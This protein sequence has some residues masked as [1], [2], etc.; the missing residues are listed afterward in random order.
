MQLIH[1]PPSQDDVV[2]FLQGALT[3]RL[4][5]AKTPS[6]PEIAKDDR[7]ASCDSNTEGKCTTK[8]KDEL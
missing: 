4:R 8:P 7:G 2:E 3:G 5:L 1:F 6:I